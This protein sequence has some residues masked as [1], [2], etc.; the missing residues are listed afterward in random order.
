MRRHGEKKELIS[1]VVNTCHDNWLRET[2]SRK[3]ITSLLL[4][5]APPLVPVPCILPNSGEKLIHR[6]RQ[7]IKYLPE[8]VVHSM[9]LRM[10]RVSMLSVS[11]RPDGADD[12]SESENDDSRDSAHADSSESEHDDSSE[13]EHD[14]SDGNNTSPPDDSTSLTTRV[15][16]P[17]K[18]RAI[19]SDSV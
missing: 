11:R 9:L 5:P 12:S 1:D 7:V 6:F 16:N 19:A 15:R 2:Y 3:E 18:R 14:D 13:S 8:K 10:E 4:P 17:R